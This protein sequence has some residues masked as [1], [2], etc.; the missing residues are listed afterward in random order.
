MAVMSDLK[1]R[2]PVPQLRIQILL[3]H[4]LK[5]GIHEQDTD[6]AG[7]GGEQDRGGRG[8]G[9]AGFGG[10]GVAGERAGRGREFRAH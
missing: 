9:E 2:P 1:V 3:W 8:G 6:I 4:T 10:E 7:G 5:K